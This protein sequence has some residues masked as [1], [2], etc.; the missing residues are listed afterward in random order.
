MDKMNN[1]ALPFYDPN[2]TYE[3]NY[4]HGPFG[5]FSHKP[6][7]KLPALTKSEF[8]NFK[9]DLP[10]GIPAGPIINSNFVKAAFEHGFSIVTYKTVR[11]QI[12]T[13]HPWPNIVPV[14]VAEDK[15]SA[16]R[17]KYP[18][19]PAHLTITNSFGV[20]SKDPDIWQ[21]DVKKAL[22]YQ[23]SGQLLI[24]GF[25]GSR[26]PE[27]SQEDFI[28]DFATCALLAKETGVKIIEVNLSC[29]NMGKEGLVCYDV[30]TSRKICEE[31]RN[32]IGDF[33]L[34]I[35]IGYFTAEQQPLLE[36]LVI[37][38][39]KYVDGISA[40]NT[41][42]LKIVDKKGQQVLPGNDRLH[43]GVCGAAIKRFGLDMTKRL[44]EIKNKYNYLF[45]IIG[46][47]GVM[48]SNDYFAYRKYGADIVQS[49]TGAM[50]NPYLA[51]QI[52]EKIR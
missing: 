49:A 29:P 10:F 23:K 52:A 42:Q 38:I 45:S 37:A 46:I 43:A 3:D 16:T 50:W 24:L 21:P 25:M 31:I 9:V 8:L 44:Y 47:G 32:K 33:P 28:Y 4:L 40:I 14:K 41:I 20:P 5:A 11:S 1:D 34:L 48:N 7:K 19:D 2:K 51:L 15:R 17:E 36:N 30:E 6:K 27:S 35:K 22:S 18:K 26:K 39:S 13:S 12:F